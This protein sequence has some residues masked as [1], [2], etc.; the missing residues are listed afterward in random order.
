[1]GGTIPT[2]EILKGGSPAWWL[3]MDQ[4]NHLHTYGREI[5]SMSINTCVLCREGKPLTLSGL[6]LP[7]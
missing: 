3:M 7:M 2:G 4:Q 5:P 1:M 6:V